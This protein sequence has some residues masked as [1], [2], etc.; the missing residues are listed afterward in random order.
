MR[1]A[2]AERFNQIHAEHVDAI[3]RLN[4]EHMDIME[5]HWRRREWIMFA[6]GFMVGAGVLARI[7][8]SL[9]EACQ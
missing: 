6:L 3:E 7:G 4:S 9:L 1:V 2:H 5:K 8:A